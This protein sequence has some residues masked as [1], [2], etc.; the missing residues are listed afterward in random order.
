MNTKQLCSWELPPITREDIEGCV[1]HMQALA[2]SGPFDTNKKDDAETLANEGER[3]GIEWSRLY[4]VIGG[5][6]RAMQHIH[7]ALLLAERQR[8]KM[9]LDALTGDPED[10]KTIR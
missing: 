6:A 3:L 1:E 2:G 9:L 10:L 7:F 5:D 4:D 8:D